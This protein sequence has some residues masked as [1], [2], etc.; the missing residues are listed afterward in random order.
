MCH[1]R[2][3]KIGSIRGA[4]RGDYDVKADDTGLKV[5]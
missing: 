4:L 1:P 5:L 2:S 3:V